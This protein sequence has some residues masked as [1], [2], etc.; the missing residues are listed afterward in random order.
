MRPFLALLPALAAGAAAAADAPLVAVAGRGGAQ[1]SGDPTFW[2]AVAAVAMVAT[3][4]LAQR[5][6]ARRR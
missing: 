4:V 2:L 1:P 5:L 3:L 6:V